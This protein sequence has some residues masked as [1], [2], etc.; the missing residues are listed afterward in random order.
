MRAAFHLDLDATLDMKDLVE[1]LSALVLPT[2][3]LEKKYR[4]SVPTLVSMI[5]VGTESADEAGND[6]AAKRRRHKKMKLGKN[7]LYPTEEDYIRRWWG[8][9]EAD[10]DM[11]LPGQSLDDVA[12]KRLAQLRI[13]ETQLQI[14]IILE[15]LALQ[16]HTASD[17]GDDGGLPSIGTS[18]SQASKQAP[19]KG[20]QPR[21]LA[22]LAD[23]HA[24]RL[25][26]WQT[27][28]A[29]ESIESEG[30][31]HLKVEGSITT[32]NHMADVLR[33]FCVEIIVPL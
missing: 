2:T 26:I 16:S 17:D 23:M 28:T 12:K 18:K 32:Q 19:T 27:V 29:E 1:F 5:D 4:E 13:R 9:C 11:K 31:S 10:N 21:D 30:R 20:K 15:A 33:E 25:C 7:G 8:G 22:A 24:D 3:T 14:I 6:G